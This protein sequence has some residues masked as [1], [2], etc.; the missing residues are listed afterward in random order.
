MPG[1][2]FGK[3]LWPC[4]SL[5]VVV[6]GGCGNDVSQTGQSAPVVANFAAGLD[7]GWPQYR[8][9]LAGSGFSASDQITPANVTQL[10][11]VW[12]FSTGESQRSQAELKNTAFEATPVLLPAEAGGHLALCTPYNDVIALDPQTGEQRWRFDAHADRRGR[13]AGKCRGVSWWLDSEAAP[14]SECRS[15]IVTATHDRRLLAIDSLTGKACSGF[16]EGGEVKLY[17]PAE[18]FVPG[19][20]ASSS[21]PLIANGRIVVGSGVVDFQRAK[22]PHGTVQA[23]DVMTG[24]KVWQFNMIPTADSTPEVRA[25]WPD[26]V[27]D[28]S[29]SANAWAPLSADPDHDLVFIPTGAPSPDFYGGLRPG[30]NLNANSVIALSLSTG[31]V[32]WRYQFVHH[33]LWDYD[34]P[35]MPLLT[36]VTQDG[37]DLPVV[38]QVTKQGYVFVLHRL[39]GVPVYPV[40]EMAVSQKAVA[41]EW[42]SPTQPKPA[43]MPTLMNTQINAD[44]AWGLTPW[45]KS[46]CR[47]AIAQLHNEGLFTP[48]QLNQFTVLMPGS[49]G[50]ANWGGAVLWKEKNLMYVN[51]NTALFA[52]RL[53]P[54]TQ[55]LSDGHLPQAGKTLRISMQGTPYSI[56]NKTLLSPLG[57]PCVAPPWGKLMAVDL[58]TGDVRWES[59]LGSIHDMGPVKLPFHINWGTPNLGGAIVTGGGVVFIGATMDRQFRAFDA[60]TGDVLWSHELPA[61]GVASPMTYTLDGKQYVVI[62]AGGH[63]M[64][65]RPMSDQVIA[66]ALQP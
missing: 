26:N 42:V 1:C 32:V 61:D 8:G 23:Y 7:Q 18:G 62:S 40:T 35:A 33:D 44:D 66:F 6:L 5:A 38:I 2:G 30:N 53:V 65:G 57:M 10:K 55:A 3:G 54:N 29:G 36:T 14:G 25:S 41:G 50:G 28:V 56:E 16:G 64:Y 11:P 13:R 4:L 52:A 51:V 31:Q 20:I 21:A 34:T 24:K 15:R 22:T 17:S 58:S 39:T 12:T 46:A 37:E 19:D 60:L 49:L 48:L 47:R 45:D 63:H 43:F 27:G 9:D 59:P